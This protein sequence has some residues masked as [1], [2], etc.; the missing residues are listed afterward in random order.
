MSAQGYTCPN[1]HQ[2]V[3]P[4]TFHQCAF[5]VFPNP[6]IPPQVPGTMGFPSAPVPCALNS[7]F[8]PPQYGGLKILVDEIR[9]IVREELDRK[10]ESSE[11]KS[12]QGT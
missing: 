6:G 4:N 11:P 1:C 7:L 5:Q 10:P 2:W 12:D 3:P 8:R 9:K